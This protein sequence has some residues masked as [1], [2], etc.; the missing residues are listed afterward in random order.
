MSAPHSVTLERQMRISL[1]AGW[2]MFKFE[3]K[4]IY[5]MPTHFGGY[6]WK[7]GVST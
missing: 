2:I 7:P 4:K 1:T 5:S 3:E 6:D